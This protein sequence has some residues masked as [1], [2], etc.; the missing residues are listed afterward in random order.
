M[1]ISDVLKSSRQYREMLTR[2]RAEKRVMSD[3]QLAQRE[4]SM[5]DDQLSMDTDTTWDI[6]ELDTK[7]ERSPTEE[8]KNPSSKLPWAFCKYSVL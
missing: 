6:V 2:S 8:L 4:T 1:N 3:A 5:L 7:V